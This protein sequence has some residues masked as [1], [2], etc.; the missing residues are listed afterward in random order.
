MHPNRRTSRLATAGALL[1]LTVRV[2]ARA[3]AEAPSGPTGVQVAD[4]CRILRVFANTPE[5]QIDLIAARLAAGDWHAPQEGD[6]F[7]LPNGESTPWQTATANKGAFQHEQ[8]PGGYA[9][10]PVE[11]PTEQVLLLKVQGRHRAI[12]VNGRPRVGDIYEHGYV[13]LPV[14]LHMGTNEIL[15]HSFTGNLRV[16]LEQPSVD[17]VLNTAH[18]TVPDLIVGRLTDALAGATIINATTEPLAGLQIRACGDLLESTLSD[19]PV[20]PPLTVRKVPFRLAGPAPAE[21]GKT[22]VVLQ[23]VHPGSRP[24]ALDEATIELDVRRPEEPYRQT[25]LSGIDNSV[26]Y[27]AVTPAA[28][29]ADSQD[30]PALILTLHG[31]GVEAI[32][33][34]A[35]YS[36]K[37][38]AHIVA[39]T[40]RSPWG[41]DWED[42]GRLDAL[43]VLAD[44]RQQLGT[45]PRRTYLT[46]HSM[47]GH[48]VWQI[49]ATYPDC[50]A[51]IG[52]SAGWISFSTYAGIKP[53]QTDNPVDRLLQRAA[54]PSETLTLIENHRQHGVYLLHGAD[55]D[56]VPAAQAR[57][58]VQALARFHQDFAFHE[59]PR[60]GHWWDNSDQPGADCVDWAPLFEFFSRHTIPQPAQALRV[61]FTTAN[62]G[63]SASCQWVEVL[64]QEK[65]LRPATVDVWMNAEQNRIEG[66]T[67][68]VARLAFD[69]ARMPLKGKAAIELDGQSLADVE[70]PVDGSQLCLERLDDQ[71]H[72]VPRP[73]ASE[74]GPHRYGTFKDAFRNRML[75]VYG[76]G[77]DIEENDACYDKARLDAETFWYR[78]NGAVELISDSE[79]QPAA[80][81][82]RNVILFG[83]A[84][85]NSAWSGLLPDCPIQV[86]GGELRVGD[87]SLN[88]DGLVC[89]AIRPRP[90]SNRASVGIVAATGAA[91]MRLSTQIAC[92]QSR[93][94]FPDW[95]VFA[96]P[97]QLPGHPVVI[98]TGYFGAN[99][100]LETGESAWK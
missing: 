92:F 97:P 100:G 18:L 31:A 73:P 26:Q 88:S 35:S 65:Q 46:G 78:G 53:D 80:E 1:L 19:L 95:T 16:D 11:S 29:N 74:K 40:N 42:W 10:I 81:P 98:G 61:N 86:A 30:Q 21:S 22:S 44:A 36:P 99:W 55:D 7:A 63:I 5:G 9:S 85:T 76:T 49:G 83:N 60:A 52:P 70:L 54:S 32:G 14:L 68:N 25:F 57:Q 89:L 72:V 64:M 12:F 41:F 94:A 28:P 84:D 47:G 90:G 58:M 75:F 91:G 67:Q 37:S 51:A 17:A 13:R 4:R 96:S 34:A 82:D 6:D 43:E 15:I 56:N 3:Q 24:Q 93:V 38:W 2:E 66:T 27:Y 33:Q 59:E 48:G 23:V 8:L 87:R 69:V 50:F 79:F 45:D 39:A 20:I 71:W 62:P 77:G